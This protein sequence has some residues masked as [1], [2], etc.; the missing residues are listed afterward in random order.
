MLLLRVAF[1]AIAVLPTEVGKI[2]D[3]GE[4][5]IVD[6]YGD[7]SDEMYQQLITLPADREKD[8]RN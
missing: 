7:L 5:V 1:S 4:G 2:R 8:P 6:K 3:I